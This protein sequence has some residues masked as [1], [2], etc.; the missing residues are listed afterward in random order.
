MVLQVE[1]AQFI[2]DGAFARHIRK[3]RRIYTARHETLTRILHRD[4]V[5]QLEVIPA[6]AGLHVTALARKSIDEIHVVA[7]RASD[8]GVE[9]QR[10]STFAVDGPPRAGLLFGYGAISNSHIP[11]GLSRLRSCFGG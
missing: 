8:L 7:Q 4:F 11:E 9:I 5:D 10:L 1:L 6:A 3:V 2:D